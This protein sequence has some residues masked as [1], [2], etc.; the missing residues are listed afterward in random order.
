MSQHTGETQYLATLEHIMIH[1]SHYM[2]RTKVGRKSIKGMMMRFNMA[3]GF[4]IMTTKKV[5]FHAIKHELIWFLS[6]DTNI[7]YLKKNGVK[8]WDEWADGRGNL[9][10]IYGAQW[11][12]WPSHVA[13]ADGTV[14]YI[15]QVSDLMS[16]LRHN[17]FSSR[18]IVSA[19][20][21]SEL[22]DMKL[23]PCHFA[24]QVHARQEVDGIYL[25]LQL[26]QRSADMFLG[27]PF[28][29]ASYSLLLHMICHQ[30]NYLP[31]EFIW[32]GGDCHIYD[33]HHEAVDEQLQRTP[34]AFPSLLINRA[35]PN[36]FSYDADDFELLGY[37]PQP[38]IKA[39]VAV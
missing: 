31:G 39:P 16:S 15:D 22:E 32:T 11:R 21:V 10:P 26:Y 25:D 33:N 1:G 3:D 38:A 35:A 9:G 19:W 6:G 2:D 29:I 17:P 20:N 13:G 24:W 18:N 34:G 12:T 36:I 5:S 28:N 30:L 7:G 37:L 27:V 23:P 8:I 4:P 14:E